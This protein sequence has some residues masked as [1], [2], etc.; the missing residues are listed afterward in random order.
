LGLLYIKDKD[1]YPVLTF[2]KKGSKSG[3]ICALKIQVDY[4][5]AVCLNVSPISFRVVAD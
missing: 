2:S 5:V 3:R 1:T 4:F